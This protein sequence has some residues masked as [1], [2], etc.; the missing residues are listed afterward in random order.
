VNDKKKA[1]VEKAQ[2]EATER[3][4]KAIVSLAHCLGRSDVY[5]HHHDGLVRETLEAGGSAAF[6]TVKKLR[7]AAY[8]CAWFAGLAA[9]IERYQQLTENGTLPRSDSLDRL[10]TPE[11]VDLLKPFRNAV[12]HCSD[13]DDDRVL[14]LLGTPHTTPDLAAEIAS[15]FRSYFQQ[16]SSRPIYVSDSDSDEQ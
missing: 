9:V 2:V 7:F 15:V 1:R 4:Q 10:I 6:S 12:A 14:N 5:R 8:V 16:H 13:H 3:R 11:F